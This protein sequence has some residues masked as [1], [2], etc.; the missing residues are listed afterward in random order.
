MVKKSLLTFQFSDIPGR[1]FRERRD[2][3]G[4]LVRLDHGAVRLRDPRPTLS[5]RGLPV[6]LREAAG[7]EVVQV[8][9]HRCQLLRGQSN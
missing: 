5:A 3:Q 8:R 6:P 1:V 4:G 9:V 7:H 2:Q